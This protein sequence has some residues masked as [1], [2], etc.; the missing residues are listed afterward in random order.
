MLYTEMDWKACGHMVNYSYSV[1]CYS[2]EK[3]ELKNVTEETDQ[4]NVMQAAV[5]AIWKKRTDVKFKID[6][7]CEPGLGPY[8]GD[9][10]EFKTDFDYHV[11]GLENCNS[12]TIEAR[13]GFKVWYADRIDTAP[14]D[15][16]NWTIKV[17]P[18]TCRLVCYCLN[19]NKDTVLQMIMRKT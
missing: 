17:M 19:L 6:D 18:D 10:I 3:V 5:R 9:F 4:Y 14:G 7:I 11:I 2:K 16:H 13:M 12:E 8:S 1:T 15:S